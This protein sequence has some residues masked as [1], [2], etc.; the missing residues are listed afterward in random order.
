VALG[1]GAVLWLTDGPPASPPNRVSV[2]VAITP[3]AGMVLINFP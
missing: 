3:A 1:A 2:H